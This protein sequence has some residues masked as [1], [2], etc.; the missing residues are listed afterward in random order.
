MVKY[1]ATRV[2][3]DVYKKIFA[4]KIR[5]ERAGEELLGKPVKLPLTK[6]LRII[7]DKQTYITD[8]EMI[9][10]IRGKRRR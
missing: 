1:I 10:M 5:L 8:D 7:V 2:P 6:V 9:R 4:K 3:E